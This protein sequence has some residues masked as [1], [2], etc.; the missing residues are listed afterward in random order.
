M[1]SLQYTCLLKPR[2]W[3]KLSNKC[4]KLESSEELNIKSSVQRGRRGKK[5]DFKKV[6]MRVLHENVNSKELI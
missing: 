5:S 3:T 6:E 1:G 2:E 4:V